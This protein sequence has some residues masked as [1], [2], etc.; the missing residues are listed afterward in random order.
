M[1]G[2]WLL[3]GGLVSVLN[4]LTRWWIVA[5]LRPDMR[6]SALLLTLSGMVVRLAL[7]AALLIG[8]L[9]Q[10]IVPG[11]LAFGGLWLTRLATVIWVQTSEFPWT[12]APKDG[13]PRL[14]NTRQNG[15]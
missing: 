12:Y 4:T 2:L 7:V 6:R 14:L 13:P 15:H 8:G 5:R 10:G 9:K 1:I 11:L 3:A